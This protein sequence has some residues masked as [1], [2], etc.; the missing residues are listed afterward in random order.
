MGRY[1]SRHDGVL[2]IYVTKN[3]PMADL[4]LF[5][6]E[7]ELFDPDEPKRVNERMAIITGAAEANADKTEIILSLN[8]FKKRDHPK[9]VLEHYY[10]VGDDSVFEDNHMGQEDAESKEAEMP[11]ERREMDVIIPR[12]TSPTMGYSSDNREDVKDDVGAPAG[13]MRKPQGPAAEIHDEDQYRRPASE[14]ELIDSLVLWMR[15]QGFQIEKEREPPEIEAPRRGRNDT[16]DEKSAGDEL[17]EL[18]SETLKAKATPRPTPP[19]ESSLDELLRQISNYVKSITP[20]PQETEAPKTALD[21]LIDEF[22]QFVKSR[23]PAPAE[24]EAPSPST[25]ELIKWISDYLR[26]QAVETTQ[27]IHRRHTIEEEL[28]RHIVEYVK[29]RLPIWGSDAGETRGPPSNE[30]HRQL[31]MLRWSEQVAPLKTEVKTKFP[32]EVLKLLG[33]SIKKEEQGS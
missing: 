32:E 19:A 22:T 9:E 8:G 28:D 11:A 23:T 7:L 21:E 29:S 10:V 26:S 14:E 24:A 16:H 12:A 17:I 27:P 4:S 25:E 13:K 18:L 20:R 31:T 5:P 30:L 6:P 2:Y 15:S 3:D 33:E 1:Y